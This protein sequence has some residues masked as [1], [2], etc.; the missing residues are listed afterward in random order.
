M[1]SISVSKNNFAKEASFEKEI[2]LCN[3]IA[4]TMGRFA[5]I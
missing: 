2:N 4:M 5:Q 3:V 1:R